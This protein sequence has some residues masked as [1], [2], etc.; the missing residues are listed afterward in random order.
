MILSVYIDFL[1]NSRHFLRSYVFV[2]STSSSDFY[3]LRHIHKSDP[4]MGCGIAWDQVSVQNIYTDS[5]SHYTTHPAVGTA[6]YTC[7]YHSV[8]Y[9]LL[10][11]HHCSSG[12][13]GGGGRIGGRGILSRRI[14]CRLGG[15]G[16]WWLLCD[17]WVKG[18]SLTLWKP[19]IGRG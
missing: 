16:I 14:G 6:A 7:H 5:I 19:W 18:L 2:F 15:R 9:G 13:G 1:F 10:G 8:W 4:L 17:R 3:T 11:S 12:S